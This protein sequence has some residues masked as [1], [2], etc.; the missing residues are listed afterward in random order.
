MK[1]RTFLQQLG[2]SAPA[3]VLLPSLLYS[4]KKSNGDDDGIATD[5][6]FKDVKVVVVGAGAAGL[7]TGWFLKKRGFDVTILEASNKIG[8]RIQALRGFTDYDIELGAERIYGSNTEWYKMVEASG[9]SFNDADPSDHYF[10]LQDPADLT[11]AS[12]KDRALADQYSDFSSAMDFIRS[13]KTY[14]GEDKTVE[15]ALAATNLWNMFGVVNGLV[16]NRAGTMNS[17]LSIKG[18]GEEQLASTVDDSVFTLKDATLLSVM[19]EKFSSIVNEVQLNT[20]VKKIDYQGAEIVVTDQLGNKYQADRVVVTV[21]ITVLQD[22]AITFLPD[23]PSTKMDAIHKIGMKGGIKAHL[24]FSTPFWGDI[25]VK[26]LG[27]VYGHNFLPE[28]YISSLGR[29]ENPVLTVMLM[30]Q[31]AEQFSSMGDTAVSVMLS[32]LDEIFNSQTPSQ[33][34]V[35]DGSH[36]KDWSKEPF[37]KGAYSYPIVGGGIIFRKELAEPVADRL[38]FGGEATHFKGHSGTVHGAI[39]TGIRVSQELEASIV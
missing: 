9:K 28:I 38:F 30:G 5:D 14:I 21:P 25:V 6:K 12:L 19:E 20:Q 3:S 36:V 29:S 7:Y 17:R 15:T 33:S 2:Y 35:Q 32:Y 24:K 18:Y 10:F 34:F 22:G 1:R 27:S 11:E 23:L 8:G 31:R 16:G 13:A 26:N 39:E 4:C 37:I